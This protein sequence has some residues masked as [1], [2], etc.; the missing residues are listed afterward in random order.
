MHI[1]NKI[2]VFISYADEDQEIAIKLY[3][4][5]KRAGA[6]PWMASEDILPGQ[7]QKIEIGE[8]I[9]SSEY[10]L[11]LL[12]SNSVSKKGYVKNEQKLALKLLD[13]LPADEIFV[14]PVRL[15]DCNLAEEKLVALRQVGLFPSYEKGWEQILRV[16]DI[17][18][19]ENDKPV[20]P[21]GITWVSASA[22]VVILSVIIFLY[23]IP[24][25]LQPG[26]CV[27]IK[28]EKPCGGW[29]VNLKPNDTGIIKEELGNG[30]YRVDFPVH[31][32]TVK[33]YNACLEDLEEVECPPLPPPVEF[34]IGECV[35]IK[36]GKP[37]NSLPD[38]LKPGDIG[39]IKAKL[40]DRTYYVDFPP[41][42]P[43]LTAYNACPED[44][45]KAECPP[46][47]PSV[48]FEIDDC[49]QIKEG[50][51]YGDWPDSLKPG[52]MGIIKEK[53]PDGTYFVDFPPHR[54]TLTNCDVYAEDLE[55]VECPAPS[56]AEFQIGDCV[57]IKK[58]EPCGGWA[59]N[60]KPGDIGIIKKNLENGTV[61]ADFPPFRPTL[62]DYNACAEDLE[63]A[64]C[65]APS[66]AEFQIG[67]CVRIKKGEPC[68]GWAENLKSG[69]IGI[70]KQKLENGIV[71][72]DFPPFS[73]T[74][75]DYNVCLEDLEKV[76]CPAEFQ[77]GDCVRIKKREPCGGW[78]ENLKPGDIG[79]IKKNLENG[80]VY[81][82]FPPFRPTLIDYNAC[83]KD[84]EKV[85]CQ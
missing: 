83:P 68:G 48:E 82:D 29:P 67:D 62:I 8:A 84:L 9:K 22:S 7:N 78:V 57:R 37:C 36:E 81:A 6:K 51:P 3:N 55:K 53:S 4:D 66:Q 65:P 58:G 73:P 23:F 35:Q 71:Y 60:L 20:L 54:P 46:F 11:A 63:K 17:P 41:H 5:L 28:G 74:L 24:R 38:N 45:E 76:K 56:Q 12:S 49:V 33:D 14:I 32:P 44:L 40:K 13:P 18:A 2:Q 30:T 77:I 80:T 52:D 31:R 59:E 70:I 10:F 79:I 19:I 47:P 39:I 50:K 26:N 15:D 25:S 75:I 42:W 85:K 43:A 27:R 34:K 64:E 16:L 61:Y 1:T 21:T 72:A 69:D